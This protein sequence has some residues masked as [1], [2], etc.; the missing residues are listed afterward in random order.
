VYEDP[1][2]DP[3]DTVIRDPDR[4]APIDVMPN[5]QRAIGA[6]V[7][8][9][10]LTFLALWQAARGGNVGVALFALL[11]GGLPAGFFIGYGARR[12]PVI[13]I[14]EEG[15][16]DGRSGRTAPWS[17][18][19]SMSVRVSRGLFGEYHHLVVALSNE[20]PDPRRQ[21][22]ITLRAWDPRAFDIP[23]DWLALPWR[24]VVAVVE[25]TSGRHVVGTDR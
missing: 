15:L 8:L 2:A 4:D 11:L 24:E 1:V 19:D 13:V 6:G 5:R 20:S 7:F 3:T 25:Q 18:I 16:T 9:A 23:V 14:G 12:C 22:F 17:T 10:A 21:P